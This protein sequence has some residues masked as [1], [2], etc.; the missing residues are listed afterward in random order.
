MTLFSRLA[1]ASALVAA[2]SMVAMPAAGAEFP[3]VRHGPAGPA[4]GAWNG[5]SVNADQYRR[6]RRHDRVDAGD[7]IAGVVILGGIAAIRA[8]ST[9]AE[10][11]A[12]S[13]CA[14]AKSSATAESRASIQSIG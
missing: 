1:G 10:S 2:A 4:I 6:W 13:T 9:P 12:Q 14:C 8:P 7:V 5:D 3:V 11:T